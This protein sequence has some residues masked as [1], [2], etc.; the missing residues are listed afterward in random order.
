MPND[1]LVFSC[2]QKRPLTTLLELNHGKFAVEW[3]AER[4]YKN[5]VQVKKML[6]KRTEK[7]APP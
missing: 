6:G 7:I 2:P 1:E 3:L 4:K 5:A